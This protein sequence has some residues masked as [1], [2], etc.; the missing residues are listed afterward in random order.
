VRD[1]PQARSRRYRDRL[2]FLR[3]S[4][5]NA[6]IYIRASVSAGIGTLVF[7]WVAQAGTGKDAKAP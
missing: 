3:A 1:G 2:G 4:P 5:A 6:R 7:R